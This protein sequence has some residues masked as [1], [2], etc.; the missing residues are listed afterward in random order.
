VNPNIIIKA[1][2]PK[3][4]DINLEVL[5]KLS[6]TSLPVWAL[7]NK[8]K[9]DHH[10]LE[11]KNHR[12]LLPIYAC[13]DPEMAF[14]KSAQIGFSIYLFLRLLWFL[15][16]N[17]G[18]KAGLYLPN[19]SVALSM[20]QDRLD[21]IIQSCPSIKA[22]YDNN[23]KLSLRRFGDSSLYIFSLGGVSSKDSVP[24]DLVAFDEVRLASAKDIDQVKHR[25]LHSSFKHTIYGSTVGLAGQ[26]IHARFLQGSQH[27]FEVRCG[28]NNGL[29]YCN[30]AET[31]PDCLVDDKTKGRVYYRCPKCKYEIKDVQ[32]GRYIPRNEG[33]D[34]TSFHASQLNSKFITP[35]EI[36]KNWNTTTDKAEW[37]RSTLGIPY[38]DEDNRGVTLEEM[39]A[40]VNPELPWYIHDSSKSKPRTAMGIDV[41]KGYLVCTVMDI[42]PDGNKKR[43]RHLEVIDRANPKYFTFDGKQ[44]SPYLRAAEMM[45]EFNVG[46]CV[47]DNMPNPDEA[48]N[49]AQKFPGK[50]FIGW[51]QENQKDVIVWGDRVKHKEG[52]RKSGYKFKFKN[53]VMINRFVSIDSTLAEFKNKNVFIPNPDNLIL[54]A[55][56]E[57][58]GKLEPEAVC[59]RFLD[60]VT[61]M[62]KQFEVKDEESGEGK[63]IW[64]YSGG[65]DPHLTHSLVYANVALERLRKQAIF[66]FA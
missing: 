14:V 27:Y 16:I 47:I 28:C 8:V 60:H 20:S 33:A 52:V 18:T 21:P 15:E 25:L 10:Y 39:K 13:T 17:P 44:Q 19:E 29:G 38:E 40:C 63:W 1:Y 22:I 24:L 4:E 64:N 58:T 43:I 62:I 12:Y 9:V 53:H 31:F 35:R 45:E 2:N 5:N 42:A 32:N 57:K 61:S 7:T 65:Q 56:N 26:T 6:Q 48:L 51:Y 23:S 55:R 36:L 34:F 41:G 46:L 37:T 54:T 50:V 30:L 49:F 3:P 59:Y 11:F 66:C